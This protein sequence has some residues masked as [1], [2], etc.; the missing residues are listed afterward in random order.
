[1]QTLT[2][3]IWQLNWYL[4][5]SIIKVSTFPQYISTFTQL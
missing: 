5:V 4:C 2:A 1:M 3:G